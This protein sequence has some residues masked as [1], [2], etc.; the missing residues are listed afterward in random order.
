MLRRCEVLRRRLPAIEHPMLNQLSATDPT[1]LGGKAR[2]VLA[3]ELHI[4]RGEAGRR[5]AE[6]AEL[7]P[8]RT[9]DRPT[10]APAPAGGGHRPTGRTPRPHRDHPLVFSY[11]PEDID[12][13][14][15]AQA[16]HHLTELAGQYRPEQL[17]TLAQRLA[18]CLHPDGNFSDEQRAT[19][20]GVVLGPQDRDGMTPIKG[21]LDPQ[22]RA[23]LDAVLAR[24]AAPGMCNP[25]DPVSTP[26][27]V[28]H[29]H[30]PPSTPTPAAPP[31]AT[32]TP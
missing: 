22:A 6:A 21:H 1:E 7:G 29:H 32:T 24:W 30:K 27:P 31:N 18:E 26:A 16:E 19:R 15:L 4:T 9:P 5:I 25:D 28:A 11:L 10:P 14:T 2:W 13:G 8:R 3:D 23:T 20:R 12:T 17:T